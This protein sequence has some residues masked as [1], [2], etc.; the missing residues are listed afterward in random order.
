MWTFL[1]WFGIAWW[2]ILSCFYHGWNE[3]SGLVLWQPKTKTRINTCP[4]AYCPPGRGSYRGLSWHT[5][6]VG[7]PGYSWYCPPGSRVLCE[8]VCDGT[9]LQVECC[10]RFLYGKLCVMKRG[11]KKKVLTLLTIL[12]IDI[13][14]VRISPL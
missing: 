8:A 11:G 6:S 14:R 13:G 5:S 3:L 7:V 12:R 4:L 10:V 1:M 9:A 2:T